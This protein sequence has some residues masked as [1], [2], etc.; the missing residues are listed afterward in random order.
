MGTII[1][2]IDMGRVDDAIRI[3]NTLGSGS[4]MISFYYIIQELL[5]KV[6]FLFNFKKLKYF[7][8]SIIV[9]FKRIQW[10]HSRK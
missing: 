7:D 2:L 8:K 1:N 6:I 10:I 3:Y 9:F 4:K 5:L